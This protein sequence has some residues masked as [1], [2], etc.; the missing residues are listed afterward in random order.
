MQI[1]NSAC[2]RRA[3]SVD[4]H[5]HPQTAH[6]TAGEHS[7]HTDFIDF[8]TNYKGNRLP[9]LFTI[10]GICL[11]FNKG[12]KTERSKPLAWRFTKGS[13]NTWMETKNKLRRFSQNDGWKWYKDSSKR[14]SLTWKRLNIKN[15]GRLNMFFVPVISWWQSYIKINFRGPTITFYFTAIQ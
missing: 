7:R 9:M 3:T 11:N 10:P 6:K 15:L 14:K 8:G 4:G 5:H 13:K 2:P 1:S 12:R